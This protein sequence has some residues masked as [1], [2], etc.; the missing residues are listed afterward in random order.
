MPVA[1]RDSDIALIAPD[2]VPELAVLV[3]R[4]LRRLRTRQGYSLERLAKVSGVSRGMLSQIELGRSTPTIGLLWKIANALGVTFATLTSTT[5]RG[6][7][8]V[9]RRIRS[10]LLTSSEGKFSSRALFPFDGERRIEFYELRIAPGHTE[11]AEPHAPGTLE[12]LAVSAGTLELHDGLSWSRLEAGDSILFE[13][14]VD[15]LYRN[16][17]DDE[18]VVYLVMTYVE[19]VG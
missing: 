10:K 2:A 16:A 9:L 3:G 12:N 8:T 7:T 4:N 1:E 11:A 13:A 19:A 17:G 6:G 18:A 14:D 15:H 5:A